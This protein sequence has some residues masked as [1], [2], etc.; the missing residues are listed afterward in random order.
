MR[1]P[2]STPHDAVDSFS[3]RCREWHGRADSSSYQL[4]VV[5]AVTARLTT[6]HARAGM[7]RWGGTENCVVVLA[8][9]SVRG[10]AMPTTPLPLRLP[11]PTA[12]WCEESSAR[13]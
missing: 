1:L 4:T 3:W 8:T 2:L 13:E 9:T 7:E 11:V 10:I 12:P 6:H 5:I